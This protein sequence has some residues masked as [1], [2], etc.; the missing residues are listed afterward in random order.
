MA[1]FLCNQLYQHLILMD[2][3]AIYAPSNA[4]ICPP[5]HCRPARR[6]GCIPG[7]M[8]WDWS[9]SAPAIKDHSTQIFYDSLNHDGI[10]PGY[11]S[12]SGESPQICL[13]QDLPQ[14]HQNKLCWKR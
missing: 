8:P 5:K 4:P 2:A 14:R 7:S 1:E 3:A 12:I 13:Y 11:T 10:P 9:H 6:P